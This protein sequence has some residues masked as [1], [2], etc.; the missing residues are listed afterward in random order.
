MNVVPVNVKQS[1]MNQDMA[2]CKIVSFSTGD[3]MTSDE[4]SFYSRA[5]KNKY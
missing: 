2:V 1:K 4:K 5:V 3:K